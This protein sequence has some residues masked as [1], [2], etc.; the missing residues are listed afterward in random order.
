MKF[1]YVFYHRKAFICC[2]YINRS[3]RT[4]PGIR[5]VGKHWEMDSMS[6]EIDTDDSDNNFDDNDDEPK[7]NVS[8]FQTISL[9]AHI[10]VNF[11]FSN[12]KRKKKL[13]QR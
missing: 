11:F 13:G 12:L 7:N 4:A 8:S 1:P 9:H 5:A 6:S 2:I 3:L 10:H